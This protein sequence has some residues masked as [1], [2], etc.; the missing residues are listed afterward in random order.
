M[1]CSRLSRTLFQNQT[2]ITRTVYQ[3]MLKARVR[4][5]KHHRRLTDSFNTRKTP[6]P[7]KA[8][9]KW[10]Q[11]THLYLRVSFL[12]TAE[13]E[14]QLWQKRHVIYWQPGTF[15]GWSVE[16]FTWA[17]THAY[18][19]PNHKRPRQLRHFLATTS[20]PRIP[21]RISFRTYTKLRIAS[22]WFL[23]KF[24][25]HADTRIEFRPV[26]APRLPW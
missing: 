16:L 19:K 22:R 2:R 21:V 15:I 14:H 26:D 4:S 12:S 5:H 24:F 10:I 17:T 7:K 23:H 1:L 3:T 25:N 9:Q 8:C 11:S 20:F 13:E 18:A 6:L